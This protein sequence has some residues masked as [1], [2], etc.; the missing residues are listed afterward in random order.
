[1]V[2]G[3]EKVLEVS[4]LSQLG[5]FKGVSFDLKKGEVLGFC[6][7][8][9]S[10]KE[11]VCQVLCGDE[12]TDGGKIAIAGKEVKFSSPNEARK[13]GVLSIPR[14]R[15]DEGMIGM[16]PIS[17][18]IN[19]SNL[20]KIA[21]LSIIPA[22][23]YEKNAEGWVNRV[24]IKCSSIHQR[25]SSLSGGNAQKVIFA[26][27]LESRCP[28]LILDHP[29][30]GVDVGS[31][32]EIYKLIRDITDQGVSIILLGDTLDE[33]IGLSSHIIVMKDGCVTGEFNCP[34][35]NKPSQVEVVQKM[36]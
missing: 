13:K 19:V 31:K 1:V 11:A 2:P 35:D 25:I 6:G 5:R 30:R 21:T 15:R 8:E 12:A 3:E 26:R 23:S 20:K 28:I 18:N 24:G 22:K 7:V 27:A 17:D 32:E 9:G 4:D 10:G 34:A 14:D 16:L 36:M 29:T 33:C